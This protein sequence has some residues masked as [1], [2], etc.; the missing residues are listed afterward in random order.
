MD[1]INQKIVSANQGLHEEVPITDVDG[2][3]DVENTIT[4][5]I[6]TP[7]SVVFWDLLPV[8]LQW[9]I[10]GFLPPKEVFSL[11][12]VCKTWREMSQEEALWRTIHKR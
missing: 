3:E 4:T 1:A 9:M 12:L 6:V 5:S 7:E 11:S 10:W 8:E 2:L